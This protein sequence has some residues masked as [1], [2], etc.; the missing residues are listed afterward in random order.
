MLLRKLTRKRCAAFEDALVNALIPLQRSYVDAL[1]SANR[2]AATSQK[3]IAEL[4]KELAKVESDIASIDNL[5]VATIAKEHP[6]WEADA[7]RRV[8]SHDWNMVA[9][10]V[11]KDD[12]SAHHAAD[13]HGKDH[14]KAH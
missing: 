8:D 3:R 4:E 9:D 11:D 6:D 2:M 13:A 10:E 5:N 12:H 1:A 7:Q 14:A